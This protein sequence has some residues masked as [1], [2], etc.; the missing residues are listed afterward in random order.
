MDI[1]KPRLLLNL[2]IILN[3]LVAIIRV[4]AKLVILPVLPITIT[5]L[6]LYPLFRNF[7]FVCSS[8]LSHDFFETIGLNKLDSVVF[9]YFIDGDALVLQSEEEVDELADLVGVVGLLFGYLFQFSL[10]L[11]QLHEKVEL[12]L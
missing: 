10:L 5:W 12:L 3:I 11:F 9:I 7:I 1:L 2:Q 6:L 4:E 8:S